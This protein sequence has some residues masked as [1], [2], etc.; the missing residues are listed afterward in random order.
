MR[1]VASIQGG[2]SADPTSDTAFASQAGIPL[3]ANY[4]PPPPGSAAPVINPN[5]CLGQDPGFTTGLATAF[6]AG[7]AGAKGSLLDYAGAATFQRRA[8]PHRTIALCT[9]WQ[10][11]CFAGASGVCMAEKT[12]AYEV[13]DL[14]QRCLQ[15]RLLIPQGVRVAVFTG[16]RRCDCPNHKAVNASW[17]GVPALPAGAFLDDYGVRLAGQFLVT[18]PE[19]GVLGETPA[20]FPAASDHHLVCLQHDDSAHMVIDGARRPFSPPQQPYVCMLQGF[21]MHMREETC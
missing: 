2:S 1:Q 19:D 8:C 4:T 6:Y 16:A 12:C 14:M 5:P 15:V 9:F 18:R 17:P 11:L 10:L 3:P 13:L 21:P 7:G 20:L